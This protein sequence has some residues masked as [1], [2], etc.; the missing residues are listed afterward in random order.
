[1]DLALNPTP[2]ISSS[3]ILVISKTQEMLDLLEAILAD[4]AFDAIGGLSTTYDL[5]SIQAASP[6]LLILDDV[7][8]QDDPCRTLLYQLKL[9]QPASSIPVIALT[10]SRQDKSQLEATLDAMNVS[11]LLKPFEIDDLLQKVQASL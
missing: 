4:E 6:A 8:G 11:V 1:M 2:R 5:G 9:R 3:N 7:N 10:T